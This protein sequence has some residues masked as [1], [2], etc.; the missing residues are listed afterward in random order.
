MNHERPLSSLSGASSVSSASTI[1]DFIDVM[2]N[3][4]KEEI[5]VLVAKMIFKAN[6]PF[7]LVENEEFKSLV[8]KLKPSYIP[9]SRRQISGKFL[10]EEFQ[11]VKSEK[12]RKD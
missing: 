2:T 6:L 3:T 7:N 12:Y 11:K 4:E 9:P 10:N 5:D 8:K 1:R